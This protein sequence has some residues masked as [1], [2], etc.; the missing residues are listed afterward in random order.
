MHLSHEILYVLV[1]F[2]AGSLLGT[3]GGICLFAAWLVGWIF[4]AYVPESLA[5]NDALQLAGREPRSKLE[6]ELPFAWSN[7]YDFHVNE[8]GV[9][10]Y[11]EKIPYAGD[12]EG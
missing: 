6:E 12:G 5:S 1:A 4:P 10:T 2:L 8:I 7:R 11:S 9:V 3:I